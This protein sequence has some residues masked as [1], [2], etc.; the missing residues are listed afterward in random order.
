MTVLKKGSRGDDVKQLQELLGINQDGIFGPNTEAA[1][2]TFQKDN[3]LTEDG[4][5]IV[6]GGETWPKLNANNTT[7]AI[8]TGNALNVASATNADGALT[9]INPFIK[10]FI[11]PLNPLINPLINPLKPPKAGN[12]KE[13][14]VIHTDPREYPEGTKPPILDKIKNAGHQIFENGPYDLNLFGIRSTNQTANSFDDWLGCAYQDDDMTWWDEFW[15]ATTD[16][17][18]YYLENPI[19]KT[20]GTA[21]LVPGQYLNVY[22]IDTHRKEKK[23]A[24]EA[25]CQRSNKNVEVW[26]DN[27]KDNILDWEG[28]TKPGVFGI[29]I[30][31]AGED[32][33]NSRRLECRLSSY[34]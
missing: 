25:L 22:E 26:R 8:S 6:D 28:E 4:Q 27:N 16:P 24:H 3:G 29:N 20:G 21:I 23:G 17:G 33:K 5:V 15:E 30:H 18:L 13:P 34:C 2:K 9:F 19:P 11:N 12:Y 31:R 32:F 14:L 10:P 7:D 1:L